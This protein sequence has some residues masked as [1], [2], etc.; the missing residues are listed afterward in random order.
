MK[1]GGVDMPPSKSVS[2]TMI[3]PLEG[4]D[5]SFARRTI[6]RECVCVIVS[7]EVNVLPLEKGLSFFLSMMVKLYALVKHLVTIQ[8]GR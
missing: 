3:V 4:I 7:V 6:I 1:L 8:W 5:V 2:A